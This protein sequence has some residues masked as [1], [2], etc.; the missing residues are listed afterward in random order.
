MCGVLGVIGHSSASRVLYDGLIVLQHRG[1]DAAGMAT[2]ESGCFHLV[3][4]SGLVRDV[5][6][7]EEISLLSGESGIAHCRYPTSGSHDLASE[8]QPFYVNFPYGLVMAHNGNL[9]NPDEV[10]HDLVNRNFRHINTSSDSELL[11]NVLAHELG[12]AAQG[13]AL[14]P[15]HISNAVLALSNRVKGAY[16]V[17]CLI[18]HHGLLAF[19]DRYGIR[20]LVLGRSKDNAGNISYMVASE[21]VA[22]DVNGFELMG[23]IKA[24]EIVFIDFSMNIYRFQYEKNVLSRPCLFE[25]IYFSRPDSISYG[26]T[27]SDIRRRMGILLAERV[28]EAG[29]HSRIDV[30]VPIPDSACH[31]ALSLSLSL[32]LPYRE[33]FVKNRYIGRTFIMS[34]HSF[35]KKSIR[36]KLNPIVQEFRGK[37]V[38]LVDDSIVRGTTSR[39]IVQMARHSG[40]SNV[41]MAAASPPVRYPNCYGIDMPTYNELIA[42]SRDEDDICKEIDADGLV[43]QDLSDLKNLIANL[44][45]DIYSAEASC[46]D[47]VYIVD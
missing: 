35:R 38:L 12:C 37:S 41:F 42:H 46:F 8:A 1:Q 5:F 31:S 4:N 6:L 13:R 22:L 21:S 24:G 39:E 23:D 11:L 34:G 44:S 9:V 16:S 47:G 17:V 30:V 18:A 29:L 27:I 3:K 7:D 10:R 26:H 20:P 32:G 40:A 19:Q 14:T 36:S 45:P 43:Y 15:D 25:Y 33:A 28:R 2:L